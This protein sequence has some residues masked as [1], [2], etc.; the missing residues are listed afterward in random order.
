MKE[1]SQKKGRCAA[2]GTERQHDPEV[3][4]TGVKV[5]ILME[6]VFMFYTFQS[7]SPWKLN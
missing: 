7:P 4:V 5:K 3:S 2:H 1:I 6:C